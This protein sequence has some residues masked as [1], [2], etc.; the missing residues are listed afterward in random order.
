L[1]TAGAVETNF[2]SVQ[3]VDSLL[4]AGSDSFP[5][6]VPIFD[7]FSEEDFSFESSF[8]IVSL[9]SAATSFAF[10]FFST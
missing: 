9:N 3:T 10:G 6:S 5:G 1:P 7:S 8:L 2:L 4:T